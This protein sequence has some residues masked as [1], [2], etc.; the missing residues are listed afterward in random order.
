MTL[1]MKRSLFLIGILVF[2]SGA[3]LSLASFSVSPVD[4][5]VSFDTAR[6]LFVGDVLLARD[7]ERHMD[8]KGSDYPF[9]RIDLFLS[10]YD[11]V[12]GNFE[13]SIPEVHTR[14]PDFTTRF[15]VHEKHLPALVDVGFSLFSLANNHSFDFGGEGY[16]H[17]KES[18]ANVGLGVFGSPHQLLEEDISFLT[19]NEVR[20]AIL[21]FTMVGGSVSVERLREML[22]FAEKQSDAQIVYIH[23][24]EEYESMWSP[25]QEQVAHVLVDAGADAVIGH[26]PHVVQGIE[27]YN[28]VPIFYSLGNFVFDQY[29]DPLLQE[30]LLVEVL[31]QA[32]T[33]SFSFKSVTSID[34]R[35]APRLMSEGEE[36]LFK[37]RLRENSHRSASEFIYRGFLDI[38]L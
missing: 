5:V 22:A 35:A 27:V 29:E 24:G 6:I 38:S 26:H 25:I 23:W 31:P 3:H 28:G 2:S 7:V 32:K 8:E 16:M 21:P 20:L 19:V 11:H 33:L 12:V 34:M 17:A 15:S 30:G 18:L 37:T 14:T 9:H 36:R 4:T 10:G 1:F 13:A